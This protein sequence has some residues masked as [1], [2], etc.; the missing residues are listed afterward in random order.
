MT[1][2]SVTLGPTDV[3]VLKIAHG[4]MHM[5]WK[6]VHVPDEQAFASIKA[7]LD[8]ASP[9][10][11]VLLNSAEFYA[12][13]PNR[14]ANLTLLSRFFTKYPEYADRALVSVKGGTAPDSLIPDTSPENLKRSV[15]ACVAAL[16]PK[17]LDLFECARVDPKVP[18]EDAIATLAG[19]VKEGLFDYI[20]VSEVSADTLRRAAKVHPIACV[21][22]EVSPWS[23]EEETRKVI[24]TAKE[25]GVSVV[26]YSPIGRGF[27]TGTLTKKNIANTGDFRS[28]LPRFQEEAYETNKKFVDA[29]AKVSTRLGITNAKLCIAWVASLGPHVIPLPGSSAPVRTLENFS[30]AEVK[31]SDEDLAEINAAIISHDILGGRYPQG[32]PLWG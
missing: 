32:I 6:D 16:A 8:L 20:G 29:L 27:L 25:L 15:D 5:T 9:G 24:T 28:H 17:K 26:A 22:I 18:V 1:I 2:P 7:G 11:K 13:A 4:L 31:L 19:F 12:N 10:Q 23:Y 30:A 21:E 3:R 14:I